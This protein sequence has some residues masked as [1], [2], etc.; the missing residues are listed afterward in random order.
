MKNLKTKR[1]KKSL[2]VVFFAVQTIFIQ[3]QSDTTYTGNITV[4][5]QAQVDAL[6]NTLAGKTRINGNL[7]IGYTLVRDSLSSSNIT[8]LTPLSNIV[9]IM[10]GVW[11]QQNGQL[12]NFTGLDSLQTIG[13]YFRV[14][15]N[16]Q[17]TTLGDFPALD[18]IG[19]NFNVNNNTELTTL[20][21]FSD[22]QSVGGVFSVWQNSNLST[23]GDFPELQS[24]G[25]FFNVQSNDRLLAPGNF[26]V[27]QSIGGYF[28]V[29]SNDTLTT[30][31]DF[32]ALQ[33]IGEYFR[34]RSNDQLTTLGDFP[35]LQ[36]IG[37]DFS[38]F[39]NADLATLG[40]FS[41]LQSIGGEFHVSYSDQLRTLGDFLILNSIGEAF[42]VFNNDQ[43]T[44]L[45]DFPALDSIGGLFNVD[46]N[47]ILKSIGDFPELQS[48]GGYFRVIRN[49]K[50][51]TLGNF[52]ALQSIGE[53]FWVRNNDQLT[54]LGDFPALQSIGEAFEVFNN[55]QLTTLG[56]FPALDSIGEYFD[57]SFNDRLRTL[58]DFPTLMSIGIGDT[59]YIPSLRESRDNV[60]IVI[61]ENLNLGLCSWLESFLPTETHAVTGDIYINNN[62][63]G[64]AT[65]EE[66]NNPPPVLVVKNPIFAHTD[67]M[68][69][70]FNIYANVR[71]QLA[72]SD[73]STWITS[74]LSDS[75][76]HTSRITGE[77]ESTITLMH[78]RA[79]N[80]TPRS[81]TLTLTAIDEDGNELIDPATITINLTQLS[82]IYEG[83]ITLS[84]QAEVDEFISNTTVIDGNL[85]IGY[86]D[87]GDSRSNIT[88]LT[89]LS[90]MTHI[91]ENL[92]IQQNGQLV[93]LNALN[94]L[95]TIGGY[96]NVNNNDSLTT[97]GDFPTLQSIG[98][99]FWVYRNS[100][101]TDLGD[102]PELQSI[103]IFFRVVN[104]SK[105]T[106]LGDFSALQSIGEY[107][108]VVNNSKLTTI[109]DFPTLQSIG[110]YFQVAFND[111]L[112]TIRDFSVLQTIGEYFYV[113]NNDS[114][115]TL[116]NFPNLTSIGTTS[117]HVPSLNEVRDSVSIVVENN[118]RLSDCCVLA[119]F[120]EQ[121]NNRV[122]GNIFITSNATG[123][124]RDTI[125]NTC[126]TLIVTTNKNHQI[127]YDSTNSIPISFMVGGSATGWTST[128][129][130]TPADASFITLDTNMNDNQ[131]GAITLMATPTVNTGVERT[132]M[133]TLTTTGI[134][135]TPATQTIVIIQQQSPPT[136]MLSTS[137]QTI[138]HN[139]TDPIG[140]S[141]M[142][143]GSATGW[144]SAI[145]YTPADASFIT[146]SPTEG[147]SQTD[148]ITI[149]ATPT[150]NTGVEERTATI[151][152]T[153]TGM[154][155]PATQTI[156]I[157]QGNKTTLS[158]HTKEPFFT[159]YPNPTNGNL[160]IEG[161]SGYLQMYIH[162][163][164]GREVMTYSLTPSKKTIDV[165][166]L[167]SGM[168]I[169]TVQAE[170]KTWTEVLIIVN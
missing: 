78:T 10:G 142:V 129:T 137:N 167:P 81:T 74:L 70:S 44:T 7:T 95:Q 4:T 104:N 22:L 54:T 34:V 123:C 97:L 88:D 131:T 60:S 63:T 76:T 84:S 31:G 36:T 24:I 154:G 146:L 125:Q 116:G 160:T 113:T 19:E 66:I 103:G 92:R 40:D 93:N 102:F 157:T 58:G 98:G 73:D 87:F 71:W 96:F 139:S 133:I 47:P 65:T 132:A 127:A 138:A 80:E 117:S 89:P 168:Y 163:L 107:F 46:N 134:M 27:L 33:T 26:P 164:V 6:G 153:T 28:N 158:T 59:V 121:G 144:T 118:P 14:R 94:N 124:D 79:P 114:L 57:V 150:I 111:K 43:L 30:L 110:E 101:L 86:S 130:Y 105:L 128:I 90:N 126:H 9:H 41:A 136:I 147:T 149:M 161:S 5:T 51:T 83:S 67:S 53:Y 37:G 100:E 115:T 85:T 108:R 50:L 151:T 35:A 119:S 21:V 13:E 55:D 72:T 162:D 29:N 120:L 1:I 135:G 16:D 48:I 17:L 145:T 15:S 75:S 141:F 20:G 39:R 18:S 61:E 77:N 82:T 109:G 38:V 25:E 159:L 91:T 8:N 45:G 165:S 169:V 143:G 2:L 69:T 52:P 42:E 166:N 56:D 106:T 140:I 49:G 23:L 156:V 152:L 99:Y 32:P 155:T 112:T 64:C 12:V 122:E 11:I 62:A 3:A 68:T 170:N 148:T